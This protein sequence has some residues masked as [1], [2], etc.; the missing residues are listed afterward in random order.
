MKK[1]SI[2]RIT[3]FLFLLQSLLSGCAGTGKDI[4]T[5]KGD[6]EILYRKGL[7]RFNK[8]DYSQALE[9]FEQIKSSFPDSPPY[10]Q[11]AEIKVGDCHF[12]K[13]E[14]VEA[15]AAYEEFRKARPTHED[16]PYVQ[17]QIA[18]A[19]FNQMRTHDRDQT[20][21]KKALSN[22]EYLVANTPPS[23]FTEKALEKI[24]VCKKQLTDHEFYIGNYYYKTGKYQAA[25]SR[26]EGLIE[27]FPKRAEEDKTLYLLGKSYLELDQWEKALDA[28]TKI[29]NDYP[30]SSH[31]KEAKMLVDQGI[32]ERSVLRKTKA[33]GEKKKDSREG[34]A[35]TVA[36]VRFE[37]EG[38][39]PVLLKEDKRES[40][41]EEKRMA[42]AFPQKPE[43]RT[44][45]P[46]ETKTSTPPLVKYEEEGRKQPAPLPIPPPKETSEVE[47]KPEEE[48]RMSAP[49]PSTQGSQAP[50]TMDIAEDREKPKEE[51][52]PKREV[53]RVRE[54]ER[55]I[56]ALPPP[57][58]K[59]REV[60]KKETPAESK[61]V[62]LGEPGE[63]IDITSDRVET[64]S[65][66]NRIVF[67]GNVMARQKDM[68]IYS[69]AIEA[70]VLEDGKGIERVVAGGNVKI[71]QG[72]RVAT[73]QQAIFYNLEQRMILT[74]DPK[75][76]EGENLVS[77]D[78]I[79][80]DIA[81]NRIEVRGGPGGRGK[82]RVLP[83]GELEKLR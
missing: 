16:I 25:V 23:I 28:F 61:D 69:D 53:D 59:E 43:I 52:P 7:E 22:F 37:D 64:F 14:Y 55:Q 39:R 82:V 78:E 24:E 60:L 79:I 32:G 74:G 41:R 31:Y 13:K 56:A 20:P 66:E 54:R 18:M 44:V 48:K 75:V 26:F 62:R 47:L 38:R 12:F 29:V 8:R 51:K 58:L 70:L 9:I 11:W 72:L 68:V 63:P 34:V 42:S 1:R 36:L 33:K 17:F 57:P 27:K 71:Q 4:K 83:G 50:E 73:C 19:Y 30:K 49:F 67:K 21:T 6:P 46:E 2:I 3:L 77:G 40:E 5:I 45:P 80:F 81:K 76:W 65:R 10:A 35:E 15:I